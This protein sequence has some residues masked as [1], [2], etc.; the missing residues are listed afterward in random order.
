[1]EDR[2]RNPL[3]EVVAA[4]YASHTRLYKAALRDTRFSSGFGMY[5]D[6]YRPKTGGSLA[7]V[8]VKFGFVGGLG[9]FLNTYVLFLLTGLY[10][11]GFLLPNAFLSSEA[12]ILVN[13]S[14]N[15]LLVFRARN[16]SSLAH[17]ILLFNLVS[18]TDLVVRL[19]LL[20][21]LTTLLS[22]PYLRSNLYAIFLTFGARFII[23]EKKIWTKAT[24]SAGRTHP[25]DARGPAMA[26]PGGDTAPPP[27]S[28]R[29][30]RRSS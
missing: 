17:R 14:L 30:L 23:S 7:W 21:G 1:M 6:T 8:L 9:I 12:A 5:P 20:W 4:R 11:V 2:I 15:E 22:V 29:S 28:G 25:Q 16:G 26:R 18:S 13:F 24:N 10:G 27:A 19:P 3:A